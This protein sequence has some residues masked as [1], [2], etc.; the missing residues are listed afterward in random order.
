MSKKNRVKL[1]VCVKG[2][3]CPKRGSSAVLQAL[4]EEIAERQ[5]KKKFKVKKSGCFGMC[6]VGPLVVVSSENVCY[7]YV[8]DADCQEIVRSH[9]IEE[10]PVTR[11]ML[12]DKKRKKG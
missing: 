1:L 8:T 4:K 6:G 12:V 5:L 10:E 2:K 11:L 9:L 3:K 7:G